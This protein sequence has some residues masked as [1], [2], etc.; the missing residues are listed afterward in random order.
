[1]FVVRDSVRD[2]KGLKPQGLIGGFN[3]YIRLYERSKILL[4]WREERV[5]S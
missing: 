4:N 2:I 3:L 5:Y 1:M